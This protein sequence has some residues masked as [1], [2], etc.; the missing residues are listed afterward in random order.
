MSKK[1]ENAKRAKELRRLVTVVASD[2]L[3]D[4]E[5]DWATVVHALQDFADVLDGKPARMGAPNKTFLPEQKFL[6]LA[7][8]L[9][10]E[11]SALWRKNKGMP[12]A[13]KLV[14]NLTGWKIPRRSASYTHRERAFA[15]ALIKKDAAELVES[16]LAAVSWVPEGGREAVALALRLRKK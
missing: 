1:T 6:Q 16:K 7:C 11:Q 15:A 13:E 4:G 12:G 2:K 9:F 8:L 14:R 10:Q 5:W 3:Y